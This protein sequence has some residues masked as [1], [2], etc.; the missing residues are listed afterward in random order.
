M[1]SSEEEI[2]PY[3]LSVQPCII[4]Q[5][6]LNDIKFNNSLS[7]K[8]MYVNARSIKNKVC[9]L[10]YILNTVSKNNKSKIDV[11]VITEHWLSDTEIKFFVFENYDLHFT[12]RPT[13]TGG[14]A[15]VFVRNELQNELYY[16]YSD[17][18][19]SI[20]SVKIFLNNNKIINITSVYRSTKYLNSDID[21]FLEKIT[22]LNEKVG[23]KE[24]LIIGDF[25][26]DLINKTDNAHKYLNTMKTYN[27]YNLYEDLITRPISRTCL[28]HIHTNN[29]NNVFNIQHLE[30]DIFDHNII[31]IENI[32]KT[33]QND[34]DNYINTK[35]I[36][37]YLKLNNTLNNTFFDLNYLNLN[38]NEM[39]DT[40]SN[41][42]TDAINSSTKTVK[43]VKKVQVNK[44]WFDCE[45]KN[46]IKSKNF[47]YNK[48]KRD[49]TNIKL[50]EEHIFWRNKVT[51]V[52]RQK[53]HQ[54]FG[55]KFENSCSNLKQTWQSIKC[56]L[57]N[58]NPPQTKSSFPKN[59]INDNMKLEWINE[60]NKHFINPTAT[61]GMFINNLFYERPY[62]NT[63]LN[64]EYTTQQEIKQIVQNL[65]N[66]NS[67]AD[68]GIQ[69]KFIKQNID[70]LSTPIM[71]IINS[72]INTGIIPANLKTSKIIPIHKNGPKNIHSNYRP[73]SLLPTVDKILE[74]VI[75]R[76]LSTYLDTYKILD[77]Q[78]YGF[79]KKSNTNGALFDI[80]SYIQL[81]LD[82]KKKVAIIFI[83]IRKAFDTVNR[84]IL[85]QKLF[86]IGIRGVEYKWFE[87][88]LCERKQYTTLENLNSET[89][90]SLMGVP[91]GGI[92]AATLFI[93]YIN[94][95]QN[96]K[97]N[98]RCYL[99]ADDIALVYCE[100]SVQQI[101]DNANTDLVNL[102][103]FMNSHKLIVNTD[104][105][106][107]MFI[108]IPDHQQYSIKYNNENLQHI[109]QFKY[110]GIIID[111]QLNWKP[112]I[113]QLKSKLSSIAGIFRKISS[114]T[115][116]NIHNTIYYSLFH[117]H[118][119]YGCTV[120]N[121]A[122]TN[123][124]NELQVIQNNAIRNLYN[125]PRRTRISTIYEQTKLPTLKIIIK[126]QQCIQIHNIINSN[127]HNNTTIMQNNS[128]HNYNTRNNNLIYRQITKTK[129]FGVNA[130]IN[131][132][133]DTYNKIPLSLKNIN[134]SNTFKTKIKKHFHIVN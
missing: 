3:T 49:P 18:N 102:N 90:Q 45:L 5:N 106:K 31:F 32:S 132:A 124:I 35:K 87:N 14:G 60:L 57:Y 30:Y 129:K 42:L 122:T 28:D 46:I 34:N 64:F 78:Q 119:L 128:I 48:L 111:S 117:T 33:T 51:T 22:E 38:V 81:N 24:N 75:N 58:G 113:N 53:K 41:K 97:L 116:A 89:Y 9:E 88:Y 101:Q 7:L 8:I 131:S 52:R 91:Q 99:Y 103:N 44:P 20:I 26:L 80:I 85:L 127:I 63:R 104:K 118:L 43:S 114:I 19:N 39:Y 59:I 115:P 61:T 96:I 110:L 83:D 70:I 16:S 2:S 125:I 67:I 50:K 62:I 93:L 112:Q 27:F 65:N 71:Q 54:Y 23:N 1:A 11:L 109:E 37:D 120:W 86:N 94:S 36:I 40:Y 84:N 133:T 126:Q 66:S 130:A 12:C 6:E 56:A 13:K 76:Q 47:W 69:I 72:T 134:N 95:I 17:N 74:T 77:N 98:G 68:D 121:S 107:I 4:V 25:N 108:K 29:L 55:N 79:R 92:L 82:K 105:T 21:N 15:A 10:K 123:Q 100:D 73:I